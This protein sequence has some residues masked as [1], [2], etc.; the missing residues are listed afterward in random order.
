MFPAAGGR[1]FPFPSDRDRSRAQHEEE[2]M[3]ESVLGPERPGGQGLD[4]EQEESGNRAIR[5]LLCDP[6]VRDQVDLVI[7][8]RDGGYEVWAAR[9][10][11]RF[12]RVLRDDGRVEFP[13]VEQVGVNP[14]ANQ[15][16]RAVATC[17]DELAAAAASGHPTEDVNQAFIEPSQLSYPH[18]Y[19]R[20]AQLFDSPFAPDLVISPRCYTFGL[21]LGQHGALDVVQSRAPLAFAGPGIRPGAFDAAPRHVDIVPT[22]CRLMGFPKID[23]KDHTGRSASER[24]VAPDVYV[25]RQDGRV[26]EEVVCGGPLPALVY[27]VLFDGLSNSELRYL[28]ETRDPAITNLRRILDR[29]ARFTYGSTVNFPSITWPSHSTILT[30][31]WCGHHDIVNPTYYARGSHAALAPQGQGMMTEGYLG[32]GVE[33]LYEAVHRVRGAH[34]FTVNIHEPQGRGADHAAL[35]GRLVAPRDRLKA[36]TPDFVAAINPRY[37]RE[38]K[39]AVHREAVLDARG[40]AQLMVLL[41][42]PSRPPVLVVHEFALTDGAGHDYGP[43]GDGLRT[44]IAETDRRL[45]QVLDRLEVKGLFDS[46]LFVFTS[47]HGMAAQHVALRAN[48]ARHL[49]RVGMKTITGE[50]MIWL[51]DLAVTVEPAPDG[52]T[53]RVIVCDNDADDSG[54]RPP[55]AGVE[56]LVHA[57][58]R[59]ATHPAAALKRDDSEPP[60]AKVVTNEL[61]I[62]GFATPADVAPSDIVLSVRHPDYNP[63]HLRLDGRNLCIDLRQELYG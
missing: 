22:I 5:A 62:A 46:T 31:A 30:G 61:G 19:E 63:R 58:P 12:R 17:A 9:G 3:G 26:L 1:R 50:P 11:V 49:E 34:A 33:T 14:I 20:V 41:D 25:A 32:S 37:S 39:E 55:L 54:E 36:L 16:H 51:R 53:A 35:E 28:L 8:L 44:A 27:V 52:R 6:E 45:G 59:F 2:P 38:G 18:A 10:M 57:H 24:G 29:A 48:P 43:H 23:G 21:Q 4:H 15:D 42:D 47:D 60:V 40:M 56:I 13:I 7:T